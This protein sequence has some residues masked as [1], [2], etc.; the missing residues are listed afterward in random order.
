MNTDVIRK[1]KRYLLPITLIWAVLSIPFGI[2]FLEEKAIAIATSFLTVLVFFLSSLAMRFVIGAQ[3]S[4]SKVSTRFYSNLIKIGWL[5]GIFGCLNFTLSG[6]LFHESFSG[7]DFRHFVIFGGAFPLGF[8]H[9]CAK[10][11]EHA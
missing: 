9:G 3:K 10:L 7:Y 5:F 4:N 8:S 11:L 6:L 1:S 2:I